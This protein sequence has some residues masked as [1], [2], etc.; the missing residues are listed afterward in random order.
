MLA[1]LLH[2]DLTSQSAASGRLP[3]AQR[4]VADGRLLSSLCVREGQR[5][6]LAGGGD[7]ASVPPAEW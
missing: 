2:V 7:T 3:A 1:E 5:H 6:S 4:K